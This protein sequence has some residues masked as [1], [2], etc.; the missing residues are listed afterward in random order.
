M[1]VPKRPTSRPASGST[2]TWPSVMPSVV[3]PSIV[4]R[5]RRYQRAMST[6]FARV[7]DPA[8]PAPPSTG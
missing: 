2:I 4:A 6:E 1:V 3:R 5:S 7:A 8:N